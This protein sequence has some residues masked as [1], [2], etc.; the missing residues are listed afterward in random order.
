MLSYR[1]GGCGHH[2][3][4][5]R[6]PVVLRAEWQSTGAF[7]DR[8]GRHPDR[9]SGVCW[10]GLAR[11]CVALATRVAAGPRA[12]SAGADPHRRSRA[13]LARPG[14]CRTLR[15]ALRCRGSADPGEPRRRTTRPDGARTATESWRE[16][17]RVR[18]RQFPQYLRGA[19]LRRP[20]DW[21]LRLVNSLRRPV[22]PQRSLRGLDHA[23]HVHAAARTRVW[24]AA[25]PNALQEMLAFEFQR[26]G[27]IQSRTENVAGAIRQLKFAERG[28]LVVNAPIEDLDLLHRFQ[29][30]VHNHFLAPDNTGA[31]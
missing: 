31:A 13:D 10:S 7:F 9:V 23:H 8:R 16:F 14:R 11:L 12:G 26:L 3:A 29:V 19:L 18:S 21:H 25:G 22:T 20:L 5:L 27:C 30:V 28:R 17:H 15:R 24:R 2:A 4:V 6:L 1:D